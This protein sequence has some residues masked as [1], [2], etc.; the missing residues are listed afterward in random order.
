MRMSEYNRLK[1]RRI[2]WRKELEKPTSK[3]S[4]RAVR[5]AIADLTEQM[6]KALSRVDP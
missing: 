5:A 1:K 4:K 2:A 6:G 3:Y